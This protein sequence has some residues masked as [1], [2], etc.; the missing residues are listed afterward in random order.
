MHKSS[1]A[2]SLQAVKSTNLHVALVEQPHSLVTPGAITG[3]DLGFLSNSLEDHRSV[4]SSLPQTTDS[5]T[6]N[7][8]R[9]V[10]C[11]PSPVAACFCKVETLHD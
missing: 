11:M 5:E 10:V 1:I 9:P 6:V 3:I 7:P 4:P 8:P 2:G